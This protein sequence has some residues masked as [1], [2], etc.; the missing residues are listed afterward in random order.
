MK[1]QSEKTKDQCPGT[2]SET[3]DPEPDVTVDSA[4]RSLIDNRKSEKRSG[5]VQGD[6]TTPTFRVPKERP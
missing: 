4:T 1:G 6:E 5:K 2:E 3:K